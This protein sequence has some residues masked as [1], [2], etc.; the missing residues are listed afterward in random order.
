MTFRFVL[1]LGAASIRNVALAAA[2]GAL[3]ALMVAPPAAAQTAGATL[4]GP[5]ISRVAEPALVTGI[6]Y[7]RGQ[8]VTV[9]VTSPDGQQTTQGLMTSADG[10]LSYELTGAQAGRYRVVVRDSG[11]RVLSA[12]VVR[13]VQ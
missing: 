6:G 5:S 3:G 9:Y 1:S 4:H 8:S 7:P 2:V 11:G 13:L 10:G 12:A